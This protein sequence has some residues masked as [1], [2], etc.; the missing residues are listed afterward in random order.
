MVTRIKLPPFIVT[1]GTLS[2]FTAITLIYA[3]GQTITL[4][5]N[6]FLLWTGKSFSIGSVNITNGVVLMMVLVSDR[7]V[8]AA[9]HR[10]GQASVRDR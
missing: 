5:P 4:N 2:I 9:L 10:V 8:R 6:T 7:R 3:K 1:L